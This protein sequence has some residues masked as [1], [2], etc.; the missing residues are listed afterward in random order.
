[1]PAVSGST[2]DGLDGSC[3]L[4]GA[5]AAETAETAAAAAV[6]DGTAGA[7]A[8]LVLPAVSGSTGDGLDGSGSL[9]SSSAAEAAAAAADAD[10]TTGAAAELAFAEL[11]FAKLAEGGPAGDATDR[12]VEAEAETGATAGVAEARRGKPPRR[13]RRC[14][15]EGGARTGGD[16]AGSARGLG[17]AA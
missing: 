14:E 16:T 7:A 2:G 5:S 1:M 15:L 3:S 9:S 8:K 13:V 6:A 4:G 17:R 10:G 11:A 12:V